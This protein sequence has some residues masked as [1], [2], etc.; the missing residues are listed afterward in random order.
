V[1]GVDRA[2]SAPCTGWCLMVGDVVL[3]FAPVLVRVVVFGGR[4]LD[5][6]FGQDVFFNDLQVMDVPSMMWLEKSTEGPKPVPRSGH[7][8]TFM[9]HNETIYV[10]GGTSGSKCDLACRVAAQATKTMLVLMFLGDGPTIPS[11]HAFAAQACRPRLL[12]LDDVPAASTRNLCHSL[13]TVEPTLTPSGSGCSASLR[14]RVVRRCR[15]RPPPATPSPPRN[16]PVQNPSLHLA[17]CMRWTHASG[18]TYI[19]MGAF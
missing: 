5:R 19:I 4:G 3:W 10:I 9:W 11:F 1:R 8:A 17:C 18:R 16:P 13:S 15:R 6:V 2:S 12:P 7:T 14:G